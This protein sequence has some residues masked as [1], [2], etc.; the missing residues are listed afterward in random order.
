[1]LYC[2]AARL[3]GKG[4][5]CFAWVLVNAPV[6]TFIWFATRFANLVDISNTLIKVR[7]FRDMDAKIMW[8]HSTGSWPLV[9]WCSWFDRAAGI[10]RVITVDGKDHWAAPTNDFD[11]YYNASLAVAI[12]KHALRFV[13]H[14]AVKQ[15][16]NVKLR[17][18]RQRDAS[19]YAR[20]TP[21]VNES[22]RPTGKWT[23]VW[24]DTQTL[25]GRPLKVLVVSPED[26][27]DL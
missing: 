24:Q 22:D 14:N 13:P 10:R 8:M 25:S 16:T 27:D 4:S 9:F 18:Q 19:L 12:V 26:D 6:D 17:S 2:P 5:K 20:L 7:G 1:M 3:S 11:D 21:W 23:R 15:L